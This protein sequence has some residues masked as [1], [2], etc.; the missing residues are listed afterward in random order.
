MKSAAPPF[1]AF[2][3]ADPEHATLADVG[4]RHGDSL[5]VSFSGGVSGDVGAI[6]PQPKSQSSSSTATSAAMVKHSIAD[7]NSCLF[8][9]IGYVLMDRRLD[10]SRQLRQ[11][12]RYCLRY[13]SAF[14]FSYAI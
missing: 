10:Q 3:V 1:A 7:D 13:T 12:T 11:R 14:T 6:I 2:T 9:A 5:L 4:V 8:N